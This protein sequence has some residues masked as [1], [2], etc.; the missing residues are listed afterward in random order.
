MCKKKRKKEREKKIARTH[1]HTVLYRLIY[2]K[3]KL[4]WFSLHTH[5]VRIHSLSLSLVPFLP[6]FSLLIG[7]VYSRTVSHCPCLIIRTVSWHFIV[8]FCINFVQYVSVESQQQSVWSQIDIYCRPLCWSVVV[9][10][11]YDC[12]L[13]SHSMHFTLFLLQCVFNATTTKMTIR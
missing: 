2:V 9:A 12:F 13:L 10:K 6:L 3:V 5:F 7:C 4:R 1:P 11:H 8:S